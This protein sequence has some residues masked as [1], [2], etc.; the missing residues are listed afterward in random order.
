MP[1]SN[2]SDGSLAA[3]P[4][5]LLRILRSGVEDLR[6]GLED[7]ER[8]RPSWDQPYLE[9]RYPVEWDPAGLD[10]AAP[11]RSLGT[12][13]VLESYADLSPE[14]STSLRAYPGLGVLSKLTHGVLQVRRG[15]TLVP[16]LPA[17]QVAELCTLPQDDREDTLARLFAPHPFAALSDGE[18]GPSAAPDE[19][20]HL[21]RELLTFTATRENGSGYTGTLAGRVLPL[22]VD[23]AEG[24]TYFPVVVGLHLS[25]PGEPSEG[26][27][28]DPRGWTQ[29]ERATLWTSVLDLLQHAEEHPSLASVG[30]APL[31][32]PP[33]FRE[34]P[35][36]VLRS[37]MSPVAIPQVPIRS[38]HFGAL[39]RGIGRAF[40][41]YAKI[42]DL[43]LDGRDALDAAQRLF[44]PLLEEHLDREAPGW[45]RVREQGRAIYTLPGLDLSRAKKLWRAVTTALNKD[46]GTPEGGP[47]I[48]VV[49]PEFQHTT[50]Q[51][52]GRSAPAIQLILWPETSLRD[53]LG[54]KIPPVR[55]RRE[56]SPGYLSILED[57]KD[58][59][60]FSSGWYWQPQG[61]TLEGFRIGGLPMLLFPEGRDAI[62]RLEER[63]IQDIDTEL[64]RIFYQPSLFRDEEQITI[65]RLQEAI[66]RAKN[67]I[68]KLQTYDWTDLYCCIF[69]AFARQKDAWYQ[70]RVV[71]PDG[72][73]VETRPYRVLSLDPQDLRLR[74]DPNRQWGQNWRG[75]LM[76]RLEALA[77]FERQTRDQKGNVI[78]AGDR[79]IQR[80]LDGRQGIQEGNVPDDDPGLGL[81]RLLRASGAIPSD[82][83]F[84]SVSPDFMANLFTV[85]SDIRGLPAWGLDAVKAIRQKALADGKTDREASRLA[86]ETRKRVRKPFYEHS[87][88]L[89]S[90]ANL[91]GWKPQRK[92]LAN[93]LL[94]ERHGDTASLGGGEFHPCNGRSGSGYKVRTWMDKAGYERQKGPRGSLRALGKFLDDLAA[95]VDTLGIE[96]RIRR[97]PQETR[98]VLEV[99]QVYRESPNE[100]Q[101]LVLQVF[102]PTDLERRLREILAA[103][104]IEAI[105]SH[106]EPALL[107]RPPG[108]DRLTPA[109]VRTARKRA[110]WGQDELAQRLGLN[111]ANISRW[112]RGKKPI[113]EK[114]EAHLRSVLGHFLD[115]SA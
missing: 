109:Q 43:D 27:T 54:W 60:Y 84:V 13:E 111:Q 16:V 113:P 46:N 65:S 15:E 94:M 79:L 59:P 40:A 24:R 36:E 92:H 56:S 26:D 37:I 42:P 115:P 35:P 50:L 58:K 12:L 72:S 104:H 17:R 67:S 64:N 102:L 75:K 80:I 41:G 44:W 5:V 30:R 82:T 57:H 33:D 18:D 90:V 83:F 69:E 81:T 62:A 9:L 95:F 53:E 114:Y 38:S 107:F 68:L 88:R 22:V 28:L 39:Q 31:L 76:L 98:Q 61:K 11:L 55:F 73:E 23:A 63:K 78:D 112:E 99:L 47:G 85:V 6:R 89:Q 91:K 97:G 106:E 20:A 51:Q 1:T 93:V 3:V 14:D 32:P 71:L 66:R 25:P 100:V 70:E 87:P 7:P 29:G 8:P 4:A 108:T 77:T 52:A 86:A 96:L 105:D 103:A 74:L 48:R 101:D 10:P 110:G 34:A 19:S 49:D 45:T 21:P 2:T